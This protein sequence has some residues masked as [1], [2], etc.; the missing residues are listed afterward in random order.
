MNQYLP[1][2]L[3][4]HYHVYDYS[5]IISFVQNTLPITCQFLFE[6]LFPNQRLNSCLNPRCYC[7]LSSNQHSSLAIFFSLPS[8][9]LSQYK[10]FKDSYSRHTERSALPHLFL[11]N[12]PF[13]STKDQVYM[14]HTGTTC[15]SVLALWRDKHLAQTVYSFFQQPS[16]FL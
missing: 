9:F 11:E 14:L 6:F 2:R 12:Q 8:L 5:H 13:C 10:I 7:L 1:L 4:M 3:F 15:N 16:N